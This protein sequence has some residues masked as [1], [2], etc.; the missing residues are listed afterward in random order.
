MRTSDRRPTR[1]DGRHAGPSPGTGSGL[2]PLLTGGLLAAIIVATCAITT[3]PAGASASSGAGPSTGAAGS[4]DRVPEAVDPA[5][6][7][8]G[9]CMAFPPTSGDRH[10]TVFLDAGHGG[11]DPGGVGS[12]TSGQAVAESTVNLAIELDASDRAPGPGLP[13]GGVPDGG[14]HGGPAHPAGRVRER[15]VVARCP[16]RRGGPGHLRRPGARRRPGRDLHGHRVQLV[17]RGESGPVRRRPPLCRGQRA[18]GPAAPVGRPVGHERPGLGHPRRRGEPRLGLRLLGRDLVGQ[19]R[20]PPWPPPTT[21]SS[22]SDRRWPASPPRRARC[23]VRS[24][25]RS[26]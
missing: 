10:Q 23:R 11:I 8:E 24:S 13:G 16:R 5:D 15:T 22:C 4:P 17:G 19:H 26:T 20:W 6:M 21:T 9:A 7:A 18:V 1:R 3:T 2:A 25:N 12:T 14:H